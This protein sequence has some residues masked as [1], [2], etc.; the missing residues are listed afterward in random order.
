M[1]NRKVSQPCSVSTVVGR[2]KSKTRR[3]CYSCFISRHFVTY[4]N[5]M[6]PDGRIVMNTE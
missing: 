1:C 4:L 5:Y 2:Q 6:G 3:M